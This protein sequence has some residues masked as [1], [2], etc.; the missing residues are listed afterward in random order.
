LVFT[1]HNALHRIANSPTG[2]SSHFIRLLSNNSIGFYSS[3]PASRIVLDL[4]DISRVMNA[5]HLS[6]RRRLPR[7][8]CAPPAQLPFIEL[9]FNR[10]KPP[11]VLR[12]RAR[13]V[14]LEVGMAVEEGHGRQEKDGN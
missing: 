12:V 9:R 5:A 8:L 4:L 11:R 10:C 2:Q 6:R 13:D 7:R 3:T 14:L 1:S